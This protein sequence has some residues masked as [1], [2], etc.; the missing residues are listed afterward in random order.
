MNK[1][2]KQVVYKI[3]Q[4]DELAR[5]DDNYL[6]MKVVVEFEPQFAATA[7]INVMTNLKYKRISL[8]SITRARRKFFE[9][10]PQLKEQNVEKARRIEEENYIVEYA[11]HIP[12]LD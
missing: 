1:K 8:E 7:F 10:Y 12:R 9:E 3:L 5:K 2:I 4:E 11:N 6:I